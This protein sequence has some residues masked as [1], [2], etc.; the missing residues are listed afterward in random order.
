MGKNMKIS[1]DT[2]QVTFCTLSNR[3][4]QILRLKG[5]LCFEA[6]LDLKKDVGASACCYF[7]KTTRVSTMGERSYLNN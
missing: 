5:T 6:D 1:P 3:Q 4:W 2:K 7:W